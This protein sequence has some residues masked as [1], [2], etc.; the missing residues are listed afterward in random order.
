M[1]M[2]KAIRVQCFL[3]LWTF[4][5]IL[6]FFVWWG[7]G[8]NNVTTQAHT[9]K[10]K[11]PNLR[12]THQQ[13]W[14]HSHLLMMHE[15]TNFIQRNQNQNQCKTQHTDLIFHLALHLSHST[16]V[17]S[18]FAEPLRSILTECFCARG[19]KKLLTKIFFKTSVLLSMKIKRLDI[20][21]VICYNFE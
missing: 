10:A 3:C 12:R 9:H 8:A 1:A 19:S 2:W 20:T 11:K 17:F 6:T 16:S 21:S 18:I 7:F 13:F 14:F 5:T 15:L 4:H